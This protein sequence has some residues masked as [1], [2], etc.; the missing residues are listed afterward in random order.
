MGIKSTYEIDRE[1]TIK[2]ILTKINDC[3]NGQLA[4]ILEEF[5]ES[6]F[7]NYIV[8][9]NIGEYNNESDRVIRDINEF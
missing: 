2:V 7:R 1:T 4:N 9:N 5:D 8:R 3:T 6:Y